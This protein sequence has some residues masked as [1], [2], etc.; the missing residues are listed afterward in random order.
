MGFECAGGSAWRAFISG[1]RV[2]VAKGA[3]VVEKLWHHVTPTA[4]PFLSGVACILE[5]MRATCNE[6]AAFPSIAGAFRCSRV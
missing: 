6:C 3:G 2:R 4:Y 1:F 5:C